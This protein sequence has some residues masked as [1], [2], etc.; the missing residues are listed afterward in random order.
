M[1]VL[2][3]LGIEQA[4]SCANNRNI[5]KSEMINN[6]VIMLD[7]DRELKDAFLASVETI[8][9]V[10]R[11][12]RVYIRRHLKRMITVLK[13]TRKIQSK[14]PSLKDSD[15]GCG[16]GFLMLMLGEIATGLDVENN[17][18]ICK[19]RA[20]FKLDWGW[21]WFLFPFAHFIRVIILFTTSNLGMTDF[22]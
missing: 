6:K 15:V 14:N 8:Y 4:R 16:S 9:R 11:G 12:D 20:R 22:A 10:D 7:K 18:E 21:V 19:R 5:H 3:I 2:K 13:I 1:H 17:V